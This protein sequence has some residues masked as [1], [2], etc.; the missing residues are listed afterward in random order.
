M[1]SLGFSST[2]LFVLTGG[3]YALDNFRDPAGSVGAWARQFVHVG[4]VYPYS[5]SPRTRGAR[6]QSSQR[7]PQRN[8]VR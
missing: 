2:Q 5:A 8:L 4:R 1:L 6:H 3:D 7:T